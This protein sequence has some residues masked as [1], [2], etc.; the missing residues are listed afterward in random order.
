MLILSL[1][2]F[3]SLLYWLI[4][5]PN[6]GCILLLCSK[7]LLDAWHTNFTFLDGVYFYILLNMFEF[8]SVTQ[9]NYLVSFSRLASKLFFMGDQSSLLFKANFSVL[10]KQY[11]SEY[12]TQSPVY[13]KVFP[14]WL[15]GTKIITSVVWSLGTVSPVLYKSF[16][17]IWW[18]HHIL[19]LSRIKE[20]T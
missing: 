7:F 6:N 2:S 19:V 10:L 15:L 14:L 8:C 3:L 20:N 5:S 1:V 13:Y 18:F 11:N 17:H 12:S 4:F 9:I 16:L